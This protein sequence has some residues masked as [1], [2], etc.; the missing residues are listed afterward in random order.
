MYFDQ[1]SITAYDANGELLSTDNRKYVDTLR[2]VLRFCRA[3][4]CL[5]NRKVQMYR[6]SEG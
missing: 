3:P 5:V 1:Y 6:I 2:Q 4:G